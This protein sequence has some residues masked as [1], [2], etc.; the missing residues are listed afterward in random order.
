M[1]QT[2]TLSQC[3][4]LFAYF[5]LLALEP[6]SKQRSSVTYWLDFSFFRLHTCCWGVNGSGVLQY[7][8]T[9]YYFVDSAVNYLTI[10]LPS[11]EGGLLL[12]WPPLWVL[13]PPPALARHSPTAGLSRKI[14]FPFLNGGFW[15][16]AHMDLFFAQLIMGILGLITSGFSPVT[17]SELTK[18]Q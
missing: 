1:M 16:F 8:S 2:R 7:L 3:T 14:P 4:L 10:L 13:E 5:S 17:L 18:A 12:S 9:P 11:G 6:N 15:D